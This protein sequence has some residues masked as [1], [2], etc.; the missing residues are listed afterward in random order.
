M[1]A[2]A[3]YTGKVVASDSVRGESSGGVAGPVVGAEGRT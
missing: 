3:D 1:E 2:D